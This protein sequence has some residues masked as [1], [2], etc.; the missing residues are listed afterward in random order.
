MTDRAER[1]RRRHK[2]GTEKRQLQAR[3]SVRCT[4]A[5]RQK[6]A[7]AADAAGL[8]VSAYVLAVV[9]NQA[10]ERNVAVPKIDR[11]ALRQILAQLGR[12]NGNLYQIVRALNF[13]ET[14][15]LSALSA[16]REDV[17]AVCGAVMAALGSRADATPDGGGGG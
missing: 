11:E 12:L 6:I 4:H 14:P 5:Q 13:R 15:D 1:P 7:A 2:S 16:H 3:L 8:S 10:L 17:A 9:F